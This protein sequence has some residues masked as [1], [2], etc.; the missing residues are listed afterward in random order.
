MEACGAVLGAFHPTRL[1]RL[2]MTARTAII[3]LNWNNYHMTA[4]CIHSV[5]VMDAAEL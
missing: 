1:Y 3:I 5:L 2:D 4:E